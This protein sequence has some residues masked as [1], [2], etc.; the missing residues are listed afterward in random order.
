MGDKYGEIIGPG[1]VVG[2]KLDMLEGTLS[3]GKNGVD[4]GIAYWSE[5]LKKGVLYA[6]VSPIYV[7]D[8]YMIKHP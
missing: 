1:D 2:V 3:F 6:A 7:K 8:E 4:W 5:E